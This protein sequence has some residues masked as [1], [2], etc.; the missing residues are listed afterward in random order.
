MLAFHLQAKH[1]ANSTTFYPITTTLPPKKTDSC[2]DLIYDLICIF[3]SVSSF[4]DHQLARRYI[5][6]KH[7]GAVMPANSHELL[8]PN[9]RFAKSLAPHKPKQPFFVKLLGSTQPQK[10]NLPDKTSKTCNILQ[11]FFNTLS[12]KPSNFRDF[13]TQWPEKQDQSPEYGLWTRFA[14]YFLG[15]PGA[16]VAPGI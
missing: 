2:Y 9:G 8:G 7:H 5:W 3:N 13:M 4:F 1:T 16:F 11:L 12:L 15:E 14:S 6:S 10:N